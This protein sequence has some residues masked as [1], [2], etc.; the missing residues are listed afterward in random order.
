VRAAHDRSQKLTMIRLLSVVHAKD[1][2]ALQQK[3]L[4]ELSPVPVAKPFARMLAAARAHAK[5]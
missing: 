5:R 3:L 4:A 2:K 1:P